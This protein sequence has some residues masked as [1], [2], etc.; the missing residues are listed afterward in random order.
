M[1]QTKTDEEIER[2]KTKLST[3]LIRTVNCSY[4]NNKSN[5]NNNTC[6][7]MVGQCRLNFQIT[8]KLKRDD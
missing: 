3:Y 1:D 4:I 5:S 2:N 8:V 7:K 6:N